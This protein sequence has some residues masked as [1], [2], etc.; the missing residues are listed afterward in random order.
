MSVAPDGGEQNSADTGTG[1]D[2][3]DRY[4]T[5]EFRQPHGLLFNRKDKRSNS[6]L[7]K[8]GNQVESGSQ[9]REKKVT[10]PP[11]PTIRDSIPVPLF[12]SINY[13]IL[14]GTHRYTHTHTHTPHTHTHL[15]IKTGLECEG[16]FRISVESS[17]ILDLKCRAECGTFHCL[18]CA[19]VR[20][21][22]TL[23]HRFYRPRQHGR[24]PC[25]S[26]VYKTVLARTTGTTTYL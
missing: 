5:R 9:I 23:L 15:T 3:G 2:S 10:P 21:F 25:G 13:L 14:N 11:A 8:R 6:G 20:E 1:K 4:F 16:L 24:R 7:R 26:R 19:I 18:C 22:L 12:V 17:E